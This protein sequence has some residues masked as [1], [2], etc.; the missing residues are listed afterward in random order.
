MRSKKEIFD[1]IL[2]IAKKDARVRAVVLNGSRA[3]PNISPDI[4]QDFDI[5]F[6]VDNLKSIVEDKNWHKQFGE[7]LIMQ[8]PE[9]MNDPAPDNNGK[10]TYLLLFTDGNRIDLNLIPIEQVSTLAHDSLAVPL[11]DKDHIL[12]KFPEANESSYYPRP[13]TAKNYA[14][15]TNEF[16]WVATYVAKGLW[17]QELTYAKAMQ[18]IIRKQMMKMLTWYLGI[19]TD[20]KKNL[21]KEGKYFKK[22][23]EDDLWQKLTNTY[24]NF[25]LEDNWQSLMDMLELMQ[26]ISKKVALDFGFEYPESEDKNVSNYIKQIHSLPQDAKSIFPE[27]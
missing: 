9:T 12:P 14:D 13:P 7:I 25:D 3:N 8:T 20:F 4:F 1:L 10:F 11:L 26:I 19:K 16:W 5:A 22:Y 18:E 21:G 15:C 27:D 17:R 24:A 2:S 6:L 23:L